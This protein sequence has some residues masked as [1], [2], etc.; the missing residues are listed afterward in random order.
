MKPETKKATQR[1]K[2]LP[3]GLTEAQH[4]YLASKG[5]KAEY[6]RN[7]LIVDMAKNSQ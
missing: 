4:K 6:L 7:L 3:V 2:P 1:K 5:N